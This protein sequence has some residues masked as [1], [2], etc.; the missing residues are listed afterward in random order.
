MASN[1]MG[2]GR[3]RGWVDFIAGIP[4]ATAFK[5][6]VSFLGATNLD[7]WYVDIIGVSAPT[8]ITNWA[9]ITV[10]A[11]SVLNSFRL[12]TGAQNAAVGYPV[13]LSAGSWT[14]TLVHSLGPNRGIYAIDLSGAAIGGI[15]GYAVGVTPNTYSTRTFTVATTGLYTLNLVMSTKNAASSSFFGAITLINL[16]RTA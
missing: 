8:A 3:M 1:P 7:P 9:T 11:T 6:A 4:V 16:R 14:L 10:D 12:S 5:A 2:P 13:V 15:D